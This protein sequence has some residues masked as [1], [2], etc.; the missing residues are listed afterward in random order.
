MFPVPAPAAAC[1]FPEG[2]EPDNAPN[3]NELKL[4]SVTDL[5][6]PPKRDAAPETGIE[7]D[8]EAGE[9]S[10]TDL[11]APQISSESDPSSLAARILQMH[12]ASGDLQQGQT[13]KPQLIG[14]SEDSAFDMPGVLQRPAPV[15]RTTGLQ[16]EPV[17]VPKSAARV[18]AR[19][20]NGP[21][22]GALV[23]ST[24]LIVAVGS[25]AVFF[26]LTDLLTGK[27]EDG[28]TVTTQLIET[29]P[30][31]ASLI[32]DS[33]SDTPGSNGLASAPEASAEQ[34]TLAKDRIRQAFS[35]RSLPSEAPVDLA[36]PLSNTAT[37]DDSKIQARLA[38]AQPLPVTVRADA[39]QIAS[40]P[41]TSADVLPGALE[42][43]PVRTGLEPNAEL[44]VM[45]E[46]AT[47]PRP[48]SVDATPVAEETAEA[49]EAQVLTA[50]A[51]DFP[52][53]GKITA[54]VNLRQSGEKDASVLAVIPAGSDV[55][56][57]ECGTWWCEVAFGDKKGF[58]GKNYVKSVQ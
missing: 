53:A 11:E 19:L 44:P 41:Q 28:R 7:T 39:S 18:S 52:N 26:G 6:T 25:G 54:A 22:F 55:R 20:R 40:P 5:K 36:K 47:A 56:F 23:A 3:R 42:G 46:E 50:S 16:P 31:I 10:V 32:E 17:P 27:S 49:P 51:V 43:A 14:T 13:R 57:S 58:V 33:Q 15:R 12:A 21:S 30:T 35:A 2:Y 37:V 45:D 1:D 48:A 24:L 38:P 9:E 4:V 29:E 8:T 34:V